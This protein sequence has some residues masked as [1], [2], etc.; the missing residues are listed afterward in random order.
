M[1][2]AFPLLVL[3]ELSVLQC[4]QKILQNSLEVNNAFRVYLGGLLKEINEPH[5]RRVSASRRHKA[6]HSD[7][8]LGRGSSR[9]NLEI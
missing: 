7:Q 3:H 9:Q 2:V 4:L 6:I 5:W 8:K 1:L